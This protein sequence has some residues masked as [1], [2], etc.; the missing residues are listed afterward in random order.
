MHALLVNLCIAVTLGVWI[1]A[2]LGFGGVVMA[3]LAR[4]E[5]LLNKQ[6]SSTSIFDE[7]IPHYYLLFAG[8]LGVFALSVAG[9]LINF[10]TPLGRPLSLATCF[11]GILLFVLQSRRL[12]GRLKALDSKQRLGL[13]MAAGLA[14]LVACFFAFDDKSVA[15]TGNYHIQAT[16]WV[17]EMPIVF[18]LANIH[19][20][21]GFNN[22]LYN[23]AA[24][25]EVSNIFSS[26]RSF[27]LNEVFV[28]YFCLAGFFA[29][30]NLK[31]KSLS[32][33]FTALFTLWMVL[34]F[35]YFKGMYVEG[36]LGLLGL[37]IVGFMLYSLEVA[38]AGRANAIYLGFLILLL[39]GFFA[40]Y[41]KISSVFLIACVLLGY[42]S[43]GIYAQMLRRVFLP[44]VLGVILGLGWA[45]KGIFLSGMP[46]YPANFL[47]FENLP[48]SVEDKT[49]ANEVKIIHDWARVKATPGGDK[50]IDEGKWLGTWFKTFVWR[51]E[52]N[53]PLFIAGSA[54]LALFGILI[55]CRRR[56][57][58]SDPRDSR[59]LGLL[60]LG[61]LL[62]ICFWFFRAPDP[63][64]GYQYLLP[65]CSLLLSTSLHTLLQRLSNDWMAGYQ[66]R[67]FSLL[68]ISLI[69]CHVYGYNRSEAPLLNG[70]RYFKLNGA[71]KIDDFEEKSGIT[72]SGL[73]MR[74]G[75]C[76]D[77][78]L[79]CANYFNPNL[80]KGIF[81]QR[82]MYFIAKDSMD[83]KDRE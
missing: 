41:I 66:T 49:R 25:S 3:A 6:T 53:R 58:P 63:R 15:D 74:Y 44:C 61:L 59:F 54:S 31:P 37:S 81:M 70:F 20:R 56:L 26:I 55:L 75:H 71:K 23:F 62:G 35:G 72:K 24:L 68:F 82:D 18:G 12:F 30:L 46:A 21:F 39:L 42:L 38:K 10:F 7:K 36:V 1:V 79:P 77:A 13:A 50:L 57:W 27:V 16:K 76:L 73:F 22:I 9:G 33:I 40:V 67:L 28:F 8:L 45:L 32:S 43:M 83:S 51:N 60:L 11:I 64:F 2:L 19:T 69:F 80:Q 4:L 5:G 48:W 17:Q 29:L 52:E 65:L 14:F 34:I 78:A 47:Y